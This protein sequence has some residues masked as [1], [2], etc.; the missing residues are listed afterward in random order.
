MTK[1]R[2][3][4]QALSGNAFKK[5]PF[6]GIRTYPECFLVCPDTKKCPKLPSN[7]QEKGE[8]DNGKY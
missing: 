4:K 7:Q 2:F 1:G 3:S 5:C 6:Q 8:N